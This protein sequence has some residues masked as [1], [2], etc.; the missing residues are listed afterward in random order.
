MLFVPLEDGSEA[1]IALEHFSV[2]KY[3]GFSVVLEYN[4]SIIW[5]ANRYISAPVRGLSIAFGAFRIPIVQAR[6]IFSHHY[7]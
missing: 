7:V 3:T 1:G 5:P 6:N 4:C 2:H